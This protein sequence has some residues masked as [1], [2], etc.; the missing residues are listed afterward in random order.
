A[1]V[2]I[3]GN[4]PGSKIVF[5]V[6]QCVTPNDKLASFNSLGTDRIASSLTLTMIGILKIDNANA[7]PIMVYPQPVVLTNTN[8]P[9]IPMTIEGK[10]D[11]TSIHER[12]KLVN[13][14]GFA[15][16]AIY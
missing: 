7:P 13:F 2:K 3:P 10:E 11:K 9:N 5:I 12:I 15:Y 6:C 1:P 4:A 14:P 8:N 16:S